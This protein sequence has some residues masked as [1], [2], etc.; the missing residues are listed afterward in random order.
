MSSQPIS[1]RR[2]GRGQSNRIPNIDDIIGE[3][4]EGPLK[5]DNLETIRDNSNQ[6]AKDDG[7]PIQQK[8]TEFEQ[9]I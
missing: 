6:D 2:Q 7:N 4:Q 9:Y 5:V 1:K 3:T 8:L